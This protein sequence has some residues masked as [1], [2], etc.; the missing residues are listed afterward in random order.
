MVGNSKLRGA[1]KYW[2]WDQLAMAALLNDKV[3][4]EERRAHVEVELHDEEKRGMMKVTWETADNNVTIVTDIN[5][6]E[7]EKELYKAVQ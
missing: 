6:K 2:T 7:Y 3:V 5:Q 4:T 1:E